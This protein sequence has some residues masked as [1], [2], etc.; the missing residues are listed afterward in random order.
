MLFLN[1]IRQIFNCEKFPWALVTFVRFEFIM[2]CIN[3][4]F[5]ITFVR[6]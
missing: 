1:V 6:E 3:M 4:F 2:N 5:E